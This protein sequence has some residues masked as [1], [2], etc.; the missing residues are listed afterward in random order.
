MGVREEGGGGAVCCLSEYLCHRGNTAI[1]ARCGAERVRE[2]GAGAYSLSEKEATFKCFE[3][4]ELILLCEDI[5]PA[6]QSFLNIEFSSIKFGKDKYSYYTD[7][8]I[9]I[10]DGKC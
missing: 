9:W 3:R 4:K 8:R 1:R 7:N 10:N 5:I 6:K 2:E